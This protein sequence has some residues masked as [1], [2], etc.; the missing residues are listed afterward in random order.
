M[1]LGTV[2]PSCVFES[3]QRK[4]L[5]FRASNPAVGYEHLGVAVNIEVGQILHAMAVY[6]WVL[7]VGLDAETREAVERDFQVLR[8]LQTQGRRFEL[9]LLKEAEWMLASDEYVL[10]RPIFRAEFEQRFGEIVCY[11]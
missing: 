5:V 10:G 3:E 8:T 11:N 6:D 2:V 1:S 9:R 4:Y 7:T